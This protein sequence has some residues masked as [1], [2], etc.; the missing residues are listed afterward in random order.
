MVFAHAMANW[1]QGVRA[2]SLRRQNDDRRTTEALVERHAALAQSVEL[3]TQDVHALQNTVAALAARDLERSAE[4][5][6]DPGRR[7]GGQRE[8]SH[9]GA[10]SS[11]H[12][13]RLTALEGGE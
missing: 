7:P 3:L 11:I 8:H 9:P 13:R 5:D 4:V 6:Q 12:E 2:V 1:A 10:H